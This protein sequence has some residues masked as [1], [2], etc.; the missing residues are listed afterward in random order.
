M[1]LSE[2]AQKPNVIPESREQWEAMHDDDKFELL[3]ALS[4]D[5]SE[6]LVAVQEREMQLALAVA[7]LVELTKQAEQNRKIITVVGADGEAN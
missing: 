3:L 7:G 5:L 2:I 1:K 4:A 6:I